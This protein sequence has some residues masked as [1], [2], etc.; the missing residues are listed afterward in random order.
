VDLV[1]GIDVEIENPFSDPKY[2]IPGKEDD[3]CGLTIEDEQE[4]G[5]IIKIVKDATGSAIPFNQINDRNNPFTCRF[6]TIIF[7]KGPAHFDGITALKFVRSRYGTNDEGNDF[8]RSAR[9]QKVILAFRQK[10][11]SSEILTSPK[12][13]IDLANTF[14]QSVDTD[15]GSSEAPL[16]LKLF[17]KI[18]PSFIR[19]VVLDEGREES[20]LKVGNP[21]DYRGQFVLVPKGAWTDLAEYVQGEIFKLEEK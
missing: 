9:Q 17:P 3:T 4:N 18:D 10:V 19:H 14:G 5:Q 8:A 6:E 12:I 13:I 11:L 2:P 15:I 21:S 7:K 16:L 1:G 20:V